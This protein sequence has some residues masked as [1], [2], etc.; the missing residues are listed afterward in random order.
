MAAE[1][2]DLYDA[3]G[4][5]THQTMVRGENVPSGMY[6]LV[7]HIWP[8]NSKGEYLIQRRASTVLWKPGLWAATGGAA[9]IGE[10]PISA[11][12]RELREEIGYDAK[13]E[14]MHRIACLRRSNSFCNVYTI[15]IDL[16]EDGFVLQKEE[17]DAVR[18]CSKETLLR[19]IS[20]NKLYHYG[21]A[22]YRM[23]FN[24]RSIL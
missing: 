6:H 22:Y 5:K 7:V 9:L 20:E 23:L 21:D 19:M 13:A 16:P 24:R 15:M 17:V 8:I 2:W 12:R 3:F 11:A 10:T 4:R 1:L 18:W 14:E